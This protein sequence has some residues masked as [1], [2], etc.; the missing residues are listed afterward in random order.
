MLATASPKSTE[1]RKAWNLGIWLFRLLVAW[2]YF[3]AMYM[4][5]PPWLKSSRLWDP[6]IFRKLVS[7]LFYRDTLFR[8][9]RVYFVSWLIQY[10]LYFERKIVGS[11]RL[12]RI[13]FLRLSH[14]LNAFH[15]MPAFIAEHGLIGS[16]WTWPW[17][18]CRFLSFRRSEFLLRSKL[19]GTAISLREQL[20]NAPSAI[21]LKGKPS[22]NVTCERL[23]HP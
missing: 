1:S 20:G 13:N 9:L 15:R 16:V 23:L 7:S 4:R 5:Y 22:P 17:R 19:L 6:E 11:P 12:S 8:P 2:P 18:R 10:S 3:P 21:R 14:L